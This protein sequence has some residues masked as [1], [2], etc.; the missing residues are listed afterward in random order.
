MSM[1]LDREDGQLWRVGRQVQQVPGGEVSRWIPVYPFEEILWRI[2]HSRISKQAVLTMLAKTDY[3]GENGLAKCEKCREEL[4]VNRA[5]FPTAKSRRSGRLSVCVWCHRAAVRENVKSR[6]ARQSEGIPIRRYSLHR[7]LPRNSPDHLH[8]LRARVSTATRGDLYSVG[9]KLNRH[10]QDIVGYTVQDLANHL[11]A[12]FQPGMNWENMH[13]W[14]IDHVIPR[15]SFRYESA[16]DP[17]FL[18]CWSLSNLQPLWALD[19]MRKGARL[20]Y[21]RGSV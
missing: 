11:E 13:E 1:V 14:H 16:D 12:L 17:E 6:L 15:S 21:D 9:G 19:N 10:W 18:R 8:R 2:R 20:N 3:L 4:P 7:R 5:F